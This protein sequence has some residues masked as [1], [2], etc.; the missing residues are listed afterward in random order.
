MKE[1]AAQSIKA[2]HLESKATKAFHNVAL[3]AELSLEESMSV[4]VAQKK[5]NQGCALFPASQ[6]TSWKGG[7]A[8]VVAVLVN[9]LAAWT[10]ETLM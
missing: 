2:S 6:T 9:P 5:K 4:V 3:R 7:L 8:C 10:C 1:G